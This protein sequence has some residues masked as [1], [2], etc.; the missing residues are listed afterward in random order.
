LTYPTNG[1]SGLTINGGRFQCRASGVLDSTAT[2][3]VN[4]GTTFDLNG[5]NDEID[6][7]N[8]NSGTVTLGGGAGA[9]LTLYGP[10]QYTNTLGSPAIMATGIS[11]ISGSN[12]A[13]IVINTGNIDVANAGDVL[14]IGAAISSNGYNTAVNKVGAGSLVL[15][16]SNTYTGPTTVTQG[17]LVVDGAVTSP[18]V[19]VNGGTLGGTGN[20]TSVTVNAGGYLAPGDPL[21]VMHL[22]GS[23]VLEAGAAM[24]YELDTPSTS[25][26]VSCGS[27]ALNGQQFSDFH[28]TWTAK[29]EPGTYNL[30]ASGSPPS[31]LGSNTSGTIDGLP[32]NLAI[33]GNDLV[34]TV[35]PE[36][37]ALALLG[38][39]AI[40]LLGFWRRAHGRHLQHW[41]PRPK[42]FS[43]NNPRK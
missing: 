25:D 24:D 17:K 26:M 1:K 32:A 15:S 23:L 13:S 6:L 7:L 28:F 33:S 29:F 22:D 9:T 18:A 43:L 34:L 38:V 39:G 21:G 3:Q 20:L 42:S 31:G 16:G 5:F 11:A 41:A 8:L 37:T 30:I 10:W 36:P 14:T 12:G 40:G 4:P 2:V 35:V 27:L 19:S